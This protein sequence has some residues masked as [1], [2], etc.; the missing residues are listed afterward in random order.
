MLGYGDV[1]MDSSKCNMAIKNKLLLRSVGSTLRSCDTLLSTKS[2]KAV[3]TTIIQ[4]EKLNNYQ[5]F[6]GNCI[7]S[8]QKVY[9]DW[10][11]NN[12]QYRTTC[13]IFFKG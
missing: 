12:E 5:F 2:K 7:F 1:K 4:S 6:R 3:M 13:G 9:S 10:M 11:D 8:N